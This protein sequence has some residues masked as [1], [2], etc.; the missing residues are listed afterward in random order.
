M[1]IAQSQQLSADAKQVIHIAQQYAR[2]FMHAAFSPAHILRA[3]LHK[4]FSLLKK[5]ESLGVDVYYIGAFFA[6]VKK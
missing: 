1:S 6:I 3:L 4:D 5:L 2:E